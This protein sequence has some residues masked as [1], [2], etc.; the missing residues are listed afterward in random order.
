MSG[1]REGPAA[2][3]VEGDSMHGESSEAESR[4]PLNGD[5]RLVRAGLWMGRAFIVARG[6]RAWSRRGTGG[7]RRYEKSVRVCVA[8][9]WYMRGEARQEGGEDCFDIHG[10]D[11]RHAESAKLRRC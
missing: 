9:C 7:R 3:N 8:C 4:R 2:S 6:A 11:V 10:H 5:G 1:H